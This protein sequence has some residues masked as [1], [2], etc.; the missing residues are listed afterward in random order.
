MRATFIDWLGAEH[1]VVSDPEMGG[2][3][4]SEF[5]RTVEHN[6]VQYDDPGYVYA[7]PYAYDVGPAYVGPGYYGYGYHRGWGRCFTDEGYGRRTPCD[8]TTR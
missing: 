8:T 3:D 4:F 1:V 7:Q 5:G 6:F 2:E